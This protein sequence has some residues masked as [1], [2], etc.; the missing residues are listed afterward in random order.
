MLHQPISNWHEIII[1]PSI[2]ESK[3]NSSMMQ[4]SKPQEKN[5]GVQGVV[6]SVVDHA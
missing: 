3:L 2:W 1:T 6:Q 4:T 5:K